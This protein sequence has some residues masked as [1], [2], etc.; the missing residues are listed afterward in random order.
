[1]SHGESDMSD[2]IGT[3][4]VTTRVVGA[5]DDAITYDVHGDLNDATGERPPLFLFGAPMDATGFHALAGLFTDRPVV[6]YDPRGAG[7]NPTGTSDI[8]V[9]QHAEDLHR[10]LSDLGAG[11]VDAFGSSG[12]GVNLLA[13][14]AAHPEDVRYAVAHEPATAAHLPDAADVH[15]VV[16]DL[17]RT[18]AAQGDGVAMAKFIAF[19][20]FDGVVPSD[21]V[22]RPAPD[23]A[24]FGMPADD[25]GT[26]TNPLFRN[27]P[28]I[29]EYAPDT[30]A[31]RAFGNRLVI[32]VGVESGE[33]MPARAA[34]AIAV[35]VGIAV[36]EFP[37]DH[38]GF[39]PQPG[40]PGDPEG[41]AARL[42]G[43]IG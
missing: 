2:D 1:M 32:G 18:Y 6:T 12:G 36:T 25:D 8:T 28:S 20:M 38:G 4:A 22:D 17:K 5:G 3:R 19:V 43:V 33:A 10:V 15:A 29:L 21:Y 37:S 39:S 34:R 30:D 40:M 9:A 42:R 14:V 31:L 7:R 24:M 23:P 41:I 16:D 26:R 11:A 27:M 35:A 13:L